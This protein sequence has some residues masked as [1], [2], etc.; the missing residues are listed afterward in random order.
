MQVTV[1]GAGLLAHG[2]AQT[3]RFER[4]GE[5]LE[6]FVMRLRGD[7][8]DGVVAYRNRCAHVGFDLDMGTGRFWSAKLSRIYCMTH[9]A[10]FRPTDGVCDAGPCLGEALEKFE[11]HLQGDDA[12]IKI[13]D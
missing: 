3:F 1:A 4:D 11:A 8:F 12:I 10:C 9:G 2:E 6:G 13:E 5:T 7:E